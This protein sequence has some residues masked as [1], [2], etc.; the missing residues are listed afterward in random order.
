M[1]MKV[2]ETLTGWQEG[3][4]ISFRKKGVNIAMHNQIVEY[5]YSLI[6]KL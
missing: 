2:K 6:D 3:Y 5:R 1:A 4:Q